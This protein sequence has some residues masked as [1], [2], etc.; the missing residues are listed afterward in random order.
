MLK[1]I[2]N[3]TIHTPEGWVKGGSIVFENGKI[4]EVKSD[5][6]VIDGAEAINAKGAYVTPGGIEIH[7]HG[8][9][10]RDFMECKEDAFITAAATHLKHGTTTIF[11][12]LSS[13]SQQMI[14]EAAEVC[15]K[16]IARGDTTIMGLHL[17][18]PHLNIKKTGG[19]MPEYICNP[20][21]AKYIPMIERFKCLKRIDAAPELDGALE[22]GKFASEHGIVM[23]IAHTTA[24][25]PEVLAAYNNGYSL[26]THF[27][28]AMGGFHNVREYK[29][30]GT[31]ESVYLIDDIDVEMITDGCHLPDT[32]IRLIHKLKG[33][34]RTAIITDSLACAGSDS[35][36]IFLPGAIIEDGVCKVAD[37]SALAGSIATMDRLITTTYNAGIP[38]HDTIR[39]ASETPARIMG[40]SDRKGALVKG[41]DADILLLDS[42]AKLLAVY[43]MGNLVE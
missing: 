20:D 35:N 34:E 7:C 1:Q 15:E 5:S 17:E 33:V 11:P 29:H 21:P 19:Q 28:N 32:I 16:I 4:L 10:G 22:F 14:D 36:Y 31:V 23:G 43:S 9:G 8:G 12:T 18:G 26:A 6:L 39:M 3:G 2:Y 42:D 27:Y 30:E 24:E 25:Y 38:L 13:S 41:K 40:I 37:G